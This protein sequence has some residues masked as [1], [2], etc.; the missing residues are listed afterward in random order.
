M[1]KKSSKSASKSSAEKIVSALSNAAGDD[2]LAEQ[3]LAKFQESTDPG[4]DFFVVLPVRS[5]LL[6]RSSGVFM[7]PTLREF[8]DFIS[9]WA[10]VELQWWC[11]DNGIPDEPPTAR[12]AIF[13]AVKP[14]LFAIDM[15]SGAL[16]R[17]E[18]DGRYQPI[19]GHAD[20]LKRQFVF[21]DTEVAPGK[22]LAALEV[23]IRE[24]H[25]EALQAPLTLG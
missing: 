20:P 3:A 21:I 19:R 16:T 9:E 18:T 15:T 4:A 8:W 2:A 11:D 6:V 17:V 24:I 14:G 7:Q 1:A 13:N 5:E 25:G 10:F 12:A 22:L 23:R